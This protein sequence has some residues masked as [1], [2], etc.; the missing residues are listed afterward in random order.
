MKAFVKSTRVFDNGGSPLT[1]YS[2]V[3]EKDKLSHTS[4]YLNDALH[5]VGLVVLEFSTGL[6]LH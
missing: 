1:S 6:R 4:A 2:L 5:Q 3:S